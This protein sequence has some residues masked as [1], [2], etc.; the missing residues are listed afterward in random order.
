MNDKEL[1]QKTMNK[2]ISS[3]MIPVEVDQM[4]AYK[5]KRS[6]KVH[7]TAVAALIISI[8][9]VSG[10]SV[11]AISN[12]IH[13]KLNEHQAVMLEEE[14][15]SHIIVVDGDSHDVDGSVKVVADDLHD[16]DGGILSEKAVI[17]EKARDAGTIYQYEMYLDTTTNYHSYRKI[18]NF[19][20]AELENAIFND[21]YTE[22]TIDGITYRIVVGYA[23]K[24]SEYEN[25]ENEIPAIWAFSLEHWNNERSQ[26]VAEESYLYTRN[27]VV[28][29]ISEG[30]VAVYAN[31]K[32]NSDTLVKE[33]TEDE[34]MNAEISL[35][36]FYVRIDREMYVVNYDV[37]PE[38]YELTGH[39][40]L[41][42]IEGYTGDCPTDEESINQQPFF[43]IEEW[44]SE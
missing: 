26:I 43:T 6:H 9:V 21:G 38:T 22:M 35:N 36:G 44:L 41:R 28:I 23:S 3:K 12:I 13:Q 5:K 19:T 17:C 31:D 16:L 32:P 14:T 42:P 20:S 4:T 1:Y 39:I 27:R 40:R 25:S 15:E 11:Y 8:L 33:F 7:Y 10:G 18:G 30:N 34:Y 29:P 2:V 24:G 37:D